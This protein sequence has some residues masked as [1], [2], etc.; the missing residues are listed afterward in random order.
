MASYVNLWQSIW[1]DPAKPNSQKN[2]MEQHITER[3]S[4][5]F[6]SRIQKQVP[7]SEYIF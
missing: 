6:F 4:R 7:I 1:T 2:Q 5:E 3:N